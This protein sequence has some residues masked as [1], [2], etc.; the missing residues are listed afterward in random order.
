MKKYLI[1]LAILVLSVSGTTVYGY[2]S[3]KLAVEFKM[4]FVYDVE[5]ELTGTA[6]AKEEKPPVKEQDAKQ[7]AAENPNGVLQEAKEGAAELT[8]IPEA[9][10]PEAAPEQVPAEGEKEADQAEA[11]EDSQD[12]PST[13]ETT[14]NRETDAN[15]PAQ[16]DE[17]G[18]GQAEDSDKGGDDGSAETGN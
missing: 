8:V 7:N 4:S 17:Q 5:V 6:K 3:D 2:W 9:A 18:D 13:E 10:V 14:V 16:A 1:M 12:S 11:P 15:P